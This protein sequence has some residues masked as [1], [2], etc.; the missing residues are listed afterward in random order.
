MTAPDNQAVEAVATA[1]M[2]RRLAQ[3]PIGDQLWPD[4]IRD[5]VR[6][7]YRNEARI[8]L[9]AIRQLDPG[10]IEGAMPEV[11]GRIAKAENDKIV[12]WLRGRATNAY[13]RELSAALHA[14]ADELERWG[15]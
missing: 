12:G 14:T 13:H 11:V 15:A 2:H 7:A 1:F 4:T 6:D 8:A 9:D 3:T 10:A 5:A